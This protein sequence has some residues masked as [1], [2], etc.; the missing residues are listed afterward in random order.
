M[1]H[2]LREPL[3]T[4]N[5]MGKHSIPLTKIIHENISIVLMYAYSKTPLEKLRGSFLGNWKFLDKSI[6]VLSKEKAE[7]AAIELAVYIRLLDDEQGISSYLAATK[8][9]N[10]GTVYKDNLPDE[11]LYLRDLTNKIMHAKSFSWDVSDPDKPLLIAHSHD[12]N[13]WKHADIN[14]VALLS[15]CGNI[16]S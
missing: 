16:A 11:P 1:S 9:D 2:I 15:F 10:Y 7:K 3:D 4:L 5:F 13:R 8:G 14:L 12:L 6:F